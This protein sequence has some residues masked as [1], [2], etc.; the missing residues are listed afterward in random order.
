MKDRKQAR[1]ADGLFRLINRMSAEAD[2][3]GEELREEI[4]ASGVDPEQLLVRV[5]R[6]LGELT[7]Q[8]KTS[9][10][11]EAKHF[12]LPLLNELKRHS[13][14]SAPEIAQRLEVP[15]AFLSAVERHGRVIPIGWCV[16]IAAR[17]ERVLK[18]SR[19]VIVA[20]LKS[21]SQLEIATFSDRLSGENISYE[22]ILE[23]S[24]MD[25]PAKHFWRS[26]AS[27]QPRT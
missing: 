21:P 11:H 26:I 24:G 2:W 6:R 17:A 9:G 7:T 13:R 14:L 1:E 27:T 16:E 25:E 4:K 12:P 18:I 23:E 20:S 22:Q 8:T 10:E 15:L 19:D 5:R 3:D